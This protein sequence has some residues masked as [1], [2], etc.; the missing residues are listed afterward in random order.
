MRARTRWLPLAVW[1]VAAT[2][3][4]GVGGK[5]LF[6]PIEGDV[7]V[8]ASAKQ[9]DHLEASS[10]A[11]H[12]AAGWTK[13]GSSAD[14]SVP[15]APNT[16]T[17]IE[18][19][20]PVGSYD[21]L[22]LGDLVVSTR[23]SVQQNVL[24]TVLVGVGNGMPLAQGIY[25]GSQGVSL[26]LNELSGQL[27]PMPKFSL[28]DQF[29]RPFSNQDIAGHDVL[30][31]AFHT[32]C[33]TT[34]PLYTGLFLQL[35]KQLPPSVMLIEATTAP[36]EDTPTVLLDYA[37]RLGASWTFLTGTPQ[38]MQAFWDPFTV[39]LSNG[40]FHSST[41][42]FIDSHGFI[43]S[44]YLGIP[45][46]EG[47]LPPELVQDLNPDGLRE[48]HSH[49]NG[50][51]TP[52]I[53][54]TL[55]TIDALAPH[56][57]GDEGSAPSVTLVGLDGRRVTL[58]DFRGRPLLINFWATYC[59][60]CRTEMPLLQR[61]AAR[62]PN[63]V[64]LLVDELDSTSS[65]RSFVAELQITSTVLLDTDGKAG[66]LYR[67]TGLPTTVFV[68]SDGTVEG[69]YIGQTNEQIVDSHIAA[70]GA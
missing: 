70:I 50:W 7:L 66:D 14:V 22:K 69:R 57:T 15:A 44:Y 56:S 17:L 20:V 40:Q 25:A 52:Q 64:V 55:Q 63:L 49:G 12:S 11:L 2:V 47:Q 1:A 58:S 26:G 45:D 9:A 18:S 34:C 68:R 21:G 42:A 48:Y 36:D 19:H 6:T 59:V 62:H 51:G 23:I 10:L 13:L 41:L 29:G 35:R 33:H 24:A 39:Q 28:V 53:I 16:V 43:R 31:A 61:I 38:A 54:D 65:A 3:G 4:V 8:M 30:L 37:G 60:P 27:K 5:F 67:I 32:N 46:I